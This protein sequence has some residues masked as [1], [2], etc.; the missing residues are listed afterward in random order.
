MTESLVFWLFCGAFL[1]LGFAIGVFANRKRDYRNLPRG[2]IVDPTKTFE[3]AH[4]DAVKETV[5]NA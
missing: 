5:N 1:L 4:R 3:E 2:L